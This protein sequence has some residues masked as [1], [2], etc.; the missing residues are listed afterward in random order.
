MTWFNC[1]G[2]PTNRAAEAAPVPTKAA[3]SSSTQKVVA[4]VR[5]YFSYIA[6]LAF[7]AGGLHQGYKANYKY[8]VALFS[9]A[10]VT[11]ILARLF[12]CVKQP[13]APAASDAEEAG[14]KPASPRKAA[15]ADTGAS[16]STGA[17]AAVAPAA[18]EKSA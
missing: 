4:F 8:S 5:D 9:A 14:G 3:T 15:D 17:A 12:P 16:S 18:S 1:C 2:A 11:V 7:A 10:L 6:A 13:A